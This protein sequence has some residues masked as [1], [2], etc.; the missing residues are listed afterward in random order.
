MNDPPLNDGQFNDPRLQSFEARLAAM[1]PQTSPVQ[2]QQLLY[3]CAFAAGQRR[4]F[5]SLRRWQAVAAALGILLLGLS[6]PFAHDH[7]PLARPRLPLAGDRPKPILPAEGTSP[8]LSAPSEPAVVVRKPVTVELD[9]WQM[10][11]PGG[12]LLAE[13]LAQ[14]QGPDPHLRSLSVGALTHAILQ[15]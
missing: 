13:Q 3:E 2:Q 15:P 14:L 12:A 5:R 11:T 6:V 4:A 8:R 7:L 1:V 9:A 10:E